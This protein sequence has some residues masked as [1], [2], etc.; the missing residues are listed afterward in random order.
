MTYVESLVS[1]AVMKLTP[2]ASLCGHTDVV[3]ALVLV[4][5]LGLMASASLDWCGVPVCLCR[6]DASLTAC[7]RAC[8]HINVWDVSSMK[9]LGRRKQ[10]T[11]GVRALAYS[12]AAEV[13][14]SIGFDLFA[15]GWA[16]DVGYG[17]P[18]F[19]LNGHAKSLV[20]VTT[21]ASRPMAVTADESGVF[22][23]RY[24]SRRLVLAFARPGFSAR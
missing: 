16:L 17:A 21:L 4:P 15:Q 9:L 22:K 18:A 12:A 19:R 3:R 2:L 8:S 11:L 24:A 20:S 13:L 14:I 23:V 5:E 10:H 1:A 6:C 7:W